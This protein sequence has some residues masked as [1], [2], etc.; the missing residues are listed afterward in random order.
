MRSRRR[1]LSL[2]GSLLLHGLAAAGVLALASRESAPGAV[3][4]E[5][6][7]A[8]RVGD[9]GSAAG[10]PGPN[11]PPAQAVQR[12]PRGLR[13][14][15]ARPAERIAEPE[16]LITPSAA[17]TE[18][19]LP[20]PETA[21]PS[22]SQRSGGGSLEETLGTG[23]PGGGPLA[24]LA[25]SGRG[26]E[27]AGGGGLAAVG[28]GEGERGIPS[29]FG[30]YLVRLR[31]R[32]QEALNY[33]ASARRRGLVGTVQLEVDLLPS[34]KVASVVVRSSSSHAVLDEAALETVRRLQP[35][36]FPPGLSSR[37]LRVRVPIV[38]E[39]Q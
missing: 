38:F 4:V 12:K 39:L 20:L 9:A 10:P 36:P 17:P 35:D 24:M 34:G 19:K 37:L 26:G 5:L 32:I 27:G 7:E 30:P 13:S 23:F 25:P 21:Q 16:P 29:E 3:V 28:T 22:E 8:I 15:P 14:A 18:P 11:S 33:P 2:V 31:Q 6:G 1:L